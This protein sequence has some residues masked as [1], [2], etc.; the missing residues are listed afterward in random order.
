MSRDIPRDSVSLCCLFVLSCCGRRSAPNETK[1]ASATSGGNTPQ[2]GG[3][4]IEH[5]SMASSVAPQ[6]EQARGGHGRHTRFPRTPRSHTIK[7]DELP[8]RSPE[9]EHATVGRER[10][11]SDVD[12]AVEKDRQRGKT[13]AKWTVGMVA[14]TVVVAVIVDLACHDN[15]RGWLE[16]AFTWIEDNPEAGET[17]I[18]RCRV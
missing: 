11:L 4:D 18:I 2:E 1:D 12:N 10:I 6:P 7:E 8:R 16:D 9:D 15:V 17:T 5:A 13:R 14:L 3:T